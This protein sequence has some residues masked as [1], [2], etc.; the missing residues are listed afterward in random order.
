MTHPEVLL[1]W[2]EQVHSR[3]LV[4]EAENEERAYRGQPL[5]E[6]WSSWADPHLQERMRANG[7]G[8]VSQIPP[9]ARLKMIEW[10]DQAIYHPGGSQC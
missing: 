7:W 8:S 6:V 10:L 4:I 9:A 5:I 2:I 1:D 3:F